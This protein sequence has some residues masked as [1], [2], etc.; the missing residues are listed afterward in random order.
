M[1]SENM[2]EASL[3]FEPSDRRYELE[4]TDGLLNWALH[5]STVLAPFRPQANE[6]SKIAQETCT[7]KARPAGLTVCCYVGSLLP[8][9]P[10]IA[11]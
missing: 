11:K 5:L 9:D 1:L 6:D 8:W 3:G 4:G 2:E 7:A 10:G